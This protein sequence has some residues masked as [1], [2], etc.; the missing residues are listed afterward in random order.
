MNSAEDMG[1]PVFHETGHL[2]SVRK[3]LMGR[4]AFYT[5]N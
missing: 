1:I 2:A 4:S 5:D 3:D